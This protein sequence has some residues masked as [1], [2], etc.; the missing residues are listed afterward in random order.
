[1]NLLRLIT[2]RKGAVPLDP[3]AAAFLTAIGNTD[4]TIESAINTLVI[5]LKGY[6]IWSKMKAI[7]PMVG[8]TSTSHSYN[9]V[10]TSTY[11]ITWTGTLTHNSDGVTSGGGYGDTGLI[12]ST[13]LSQDDVH[14]SSYGTFVVDT[15][16]MGASDASQV[17]KISFYRTFAGTT[18]YGAN[19]SNWDTFSTTPDFLP[20]IGHSVVSRTGS[21][22]SDV[23]MYLNSS[24]TGTGSTASN[25]LST[26]PITV[27]TYNLGGS[28]TSTST[29]TFAFFSIGS[30]LTASEITDFYTAVQNCQITL[31]QAVDADAVS[32]I[33]AAQLAN[34]TQMAAVQQ[35]TADLKSYN[36]W[37]KCVAIYPLVGA[38]PVSHSYNLKDTSQY[39][40][41]WSGTLTHNLN[42]VVGGGGYGQSGLIPNVALSQNDSH[43][44]SYGVGP[45]NSFAFD[46]GA[47][48]N[49]NQDERIAFTRNY[50]A[51]GF[52]VYW[53]VN[54]NGWNT[55]V[56]ALGDGLAMVSRTGSAGSDAELYENG[57][58]IQTGSTASSGLTDKEIYLLAYNF[59]GS[60][61]G[62]SN[63]RYSFFSIGS[64]LDSTEA[65]DLYT[66]V[67]DYQVALGREA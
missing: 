53:G 27:C 22:G 62:T 60:L 58:S 57:I 59:G 8:G 30:G 31:S 14:I 4:P 66:V 20:Y 2:F 13:D 38:N 15:A 52:N 33:N 46:M 47:S 3:D 19:Q 35:L 67:E 54:Q 32:F 40:V 17:N 43:I 26:Y 11:Q 48:T 64:G 10:D 34:R 44:S 7:Y 42:G 29:A 49:G 16:D 50:Q 9:L 39:Q 25:G 63:A 5:D 37:S 65:A 41:T 55:Q 12:P 36:L 1:M 45:F 24:L 21:A 51:G 56:A 23:K 28:P 6:G 18:Y 61:N